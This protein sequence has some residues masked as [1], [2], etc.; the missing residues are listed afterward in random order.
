MI[1]YCI[2]EPRF[3]TY[4]ET[5]LLCFYLLWVTNRLYSTSTSTFPSA[6]THTWVSLRNTPRH[7]TSW[8]PQNPYLHADKLLSKISV[9]LVSHPWYWLHIS[10][11][12]WLF[13]LEFYSFICWS[14]S[15]PQMRLS[16]SKMICVCFYLLPGN[17]TNLSG[18]RFFRP[19]R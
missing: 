6:C 17:I 10:T 19:Y 15:R 9:L 5:Q 8:P 16:F 13:S 2:E 4:W 12:R 7:G 11:V 1:R 14:S 18:L 3:F